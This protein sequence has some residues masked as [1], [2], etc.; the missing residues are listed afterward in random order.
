MFD[1]PFEKYKFYVNEKE[2][3]VYAISTYASKTVRGVSKCA[4]EDTFDIEYGKRLAAA[5]CN[6]KVAAKRVSKS[7]ANC[8]ELLEMMTWVANCL[9]DENAYRT[10]A[11]TAFKAAVKSVNDIE[12]ERK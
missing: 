8:K 5:R 2:R 10:D 7:E 11:E 6:L 9:A 1:Y 4:P 12:M 3:T